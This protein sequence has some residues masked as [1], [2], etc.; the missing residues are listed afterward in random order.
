MKLL[1][2]TQKDGDGEYVVLLH[3]EDY[4]L[5]VKVGWCNEGY[6]VKGTNDVSGTY[7]FLLP[8]ECILRKE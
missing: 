2:Y 5:E 8:T 7:D 3:D 6:I 4:S 1:H